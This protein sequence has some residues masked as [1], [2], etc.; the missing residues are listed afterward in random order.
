MLLVRSMFFVLQSGTMEIDAATG[1]K[2][3]LAERA[4]LNA[5]PKNEPGCEPISSLPGEGCADGSIS[6]RRSHASKLESKL[7]NQ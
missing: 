1:T 5:S 4:S 6:N 3:A 2:R 7:A